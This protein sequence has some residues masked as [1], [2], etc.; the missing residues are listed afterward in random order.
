M[1]CITLVVAGLILTACSVSST[2]GSKDEDRFRECSAM[3]GSYKS[4]GYTSYADW[5]CKLPDAPAAT[6]TVTV[7][8]SPF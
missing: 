6:V 2:D 5:E 3:G 4:E 8:E 1:R 7:T